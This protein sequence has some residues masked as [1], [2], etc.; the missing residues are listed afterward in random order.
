MRAGASTGEAA[1]KARLQFIQLLSIADPTDLKTLAQFSLMGDPSLHPVAAPPHT[2]DAMIAEPKSA[3]GGTEAPL[4]DDSLRVRAAS[5]ALR[6]RHLAALGG[7]VASAVA[8][9]DPRSRRATAKAPRTLLEAEL[10]QAGARCVDVSSFTV[11]APRGSNTEAKSAPADRVDV[12]VGELPRGDA[13]F[14]RFY[15]VVARATAGGTVVRRLFS[16]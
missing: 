4:A 12:A 14:P 5:R 13:P 15:V 2:G 10:A 1:L 9:A 8:V 7:V 6:R 11:R 3:R 16:R